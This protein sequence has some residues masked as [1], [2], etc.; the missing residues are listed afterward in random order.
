MTSACFLLMSLAMLCGLAG[1]GSGCRGR[2]VSTQRFT[3]PEG[4]DPY[5][6]K[7]EQLCVIRTSTAQSGAF[8]EKLRRRIT[9]SVV[10]SDRQY[11]LKESFQCSCAELK[12]DVKWNLPGTLSISLFE[13]KTDGGLR[14]RMPLYRCTYQYDASSGKYVGVDSGR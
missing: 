9:I 4:L 11:L 3:F 8:S 2:A 10:N 1:G 14:A 6:S 7:W 12:A 5:G 13:R